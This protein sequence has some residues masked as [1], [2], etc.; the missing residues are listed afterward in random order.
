MI[1]Y[2]EFE[3]CLLRQPVLAAGIYPWKLATSAR[4]RALCS[5]TVNRR[6]GDETHS[7]MTGRTISVGEI[8]G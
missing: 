2:S 3:S 4:F 7:R 1:G 6:S 5:R 8:V